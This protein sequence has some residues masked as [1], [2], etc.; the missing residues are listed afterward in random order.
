M[1]LPNGDLIAGGSFSIAGSS[2]AKGVAR[3]NGSDWVALGAGLPGQVQALAALP[4]GEIVAGGTFTTAQGAPG[5]LIAKW[6]GATWTA[7]AQPLSAG[8]SAGVSAMAVLPTGDL[9]VGGFFAV[10]SISSIARWDGAAWQQM[11]TSPFNRV[12]S[13]VVSSTGQLFVAGDCI[14]ASNN[15]VPCVARWTGSAWIAIGTPFSVGQEI[16]ALTIMPNGDLAAGG[17]FTFFP[18]GFAASGIARWNG[19]SWTRVGSGFSSTDFVGSLAVNGAGELVARGSFAAAGGVP[20]ANIAKWNGTS[21]SAIGAGLPYPAVHVIPLPAALAIMPNGDMIAGGYFVGLGGAVAEHIARWN[22]TAWL[23]MG[24]GISSDCSTCS[25]PAVYA[26]Q[27]LPSGDIIIAGYFAI[28]AQEGLARNVARF[29]GTAWHSLGSGF[30]GTINALAMLPSGD[31]VAGGD[32]TQAAGDAANGVA[33]W[34]GVNWLP[35]G[36]G[37]NSGV[38]ALAP[39]SDGSLFVGGYFTTAGGI[40]ASGVARWDGTAWSALG[41]GVAG[42]A[43]ALAV[44]PNGDLIVGGTFATAGGTPASR[45]ARWNGQSWSSLGSG[46]LSTSGPNQIHALAVLPD[47]D[48]VAAGV[49]SSAGGVAARSIARWNGSWS[50]LGTGINGQV[51]SLAVLRTGTIVAGG[52]FSLSGGVLTQ[53]IARW[54]GSAWSPIG[55]GLAG[56]LNS[57]YSDRRALLV[58]SMASLHD[59]QVAFGG[60]FTVANG[61][62][63]PYWARWNSP[64][65]ADF[66]CSNTVELQDVFSYIAAWFNGSA[67]ADADGDGLVTIA[68]VFAFLSAWFAPC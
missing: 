14:D 31:I 53:N 61:A 34:N 23:P 64:C 2:A 63:S 60:A 27:E 20:A 26:Q 24:T 8:T 54:S 19:S 13:M 25:I 39:R 66:D 6:N 10:G 12:N 16:F 48:L 4:T 49:F 43:Y 38:M 22:G 59:G 11:G 68:D 50:A 52:M 17:F 1:A 46:M 42:S 44:L 18:D 5:N 15:L 29:D 35:L 56:T 9:V 37:V 67:T 55:S 47:G 32:F 51:G 57:G 7:F 30:R 21:W 28:N 36:S 41:T 40:S 3:W 45:I 58:S 33:R 62:V 65:L